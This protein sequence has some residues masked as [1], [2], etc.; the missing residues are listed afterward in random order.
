[1]RARRYRSTLRRL[2]SRRACRSRFLFCVCHFLH[3]SLRFASSLGSI[4]TVAK[5]S[6]ATLTPYALPASHPHSAHSAV[7]LYVSRARSCASTHDISTLFSSA[8]L[9]SG[10]S[11]YSMFVPL[12]ISFIGLLIVVVASERRAPAGVFFP[13]RAHRT[14]IFGRFLVDLVPFDLGDYGGC[15][16]YDGV[17]FFVATS[18][19][20]RSV[21]VHVVMCLIASSTV[22]KSGSV[23]VMYLL[24]IILF[25]RPVLPRTCVGRV[26]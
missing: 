3:L 2:P 22:R 23:S 14:V 12:S 24:V 18:D 25:P 19:L 8:A 10:H 1:M 11:R 16:D 5:S 20:E 9:Q 17:N 6:T 13:A 4:P 21:V 26:I 15:A 7:G